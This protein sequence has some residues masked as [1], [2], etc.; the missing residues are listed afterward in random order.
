MEQVPPCFGG[1]SEELDL[2]EAARRLD[3]PLLAAFPAEALLQPYQR[4]GVTAAFE[5]VE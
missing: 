1:R 2:L 4:Q 5:V 3:E